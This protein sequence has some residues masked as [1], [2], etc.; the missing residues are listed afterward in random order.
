MSKALITLQLVV[1][2]LAYTVVAAP[3]N[4]IVFEDAAVPA[5]GEATADAGTTDAAAT[6]AAATDAG[7]TDA[8]A[9]DAGTTD[10]G[11]TDANT[12][13]A[14]TTDAG[15]D[16]NSDSGS[17]HTVIY[18][19]IAV[20]VVLAVAGVVTFFVCRKKSVDGHNNQASYHRAP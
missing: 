9:T 10:A 12:T 19:V 16:T 11:T 7:T 8:G 17:N 14:G 18:I 2:L 6:D 5:E 20:V 1:C 4:K 15:T 13:D 3:G